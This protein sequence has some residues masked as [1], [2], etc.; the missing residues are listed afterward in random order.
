MRKTIATWSGLVALAL[1]AGGASAETLRISYPGWDSK[2]QEREVTQIFAEYEK[3]N[4]GVKIEVIST[5]FPV[6]KQKLVVSLRSGDAPDLGYLDGRWLPE[7]QAA[8]FLADVTARAEALDRKD[9]YPASW[10]PATIDGKVYAIPDRVDPWMVYYNTDLFKAAGI[11]RFPETTDELVA[12][13][14]KI[15]GNGVYAWG[16]IGANDAT[17]IGRYLNILYAFHGNLLS[18]DGKKAVVNDANG[19]AAL[20]F[21]TDLLLKHGIAQPSAL[22]NGH[23][24]VRQLFMTKQVAM[25]I[26]GPWARGTLREMAPT[27]HWSVGRIPAAPGK[28][29]RFTMTSWHYATFAAG[30]NQ[31]AVARLVAYLVQPENQSRSVVTLPARRSAAAMPRFQTDEYKPW[32]A[33]LPAG[34][35]FPI[36]DRFSE[37]ADIVGKSV[38]EVLAKRKDAKA[39]ADEATARIDKLL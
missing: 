35:A 25:I 11:D 24:D 33:A 3:R 27:L 14:R 15:T 39:A 4:P 37:I 30:K 31:E 10:E 1:A 29:P 9:W 36:T 20:A 13:G 2:E 17:F 8:G 38:Q 26:D 5:P 32:I 19:V 28:E 16:L 6:M 18:P 7:L 34:R 21:Y 23:N 22:G 12:A